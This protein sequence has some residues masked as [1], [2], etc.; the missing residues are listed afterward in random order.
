MRRVSR[1]I[2]FPSPSS[3]NL[4]Y[5]G[6][7]YARKMAWTT[8]QIGPKEGALDPVQLKTVDG[9]RRARAQGLLSDMAGRPFGG[10]VVRSSH[11]R[12]SRWSGC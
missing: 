2:S 10:G 1:R 9:L 11:Q 12:E 5:S 7:G 4:K 3:I 6:V 8:F